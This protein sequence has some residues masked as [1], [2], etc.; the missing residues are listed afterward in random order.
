QL[1]THLALRVECFCVDALLREAVHQEIGAATGDEQLRRRG[2]LPLVVGARVGDLAFALERLVG[3]VAHVYR[4]IQAFLGGLLRRAAPRPNVTRQVEEPAAAAGNF[5]RTPRRFDRELRRG[6]RAGARDLVG[7]GSD[8][9]RAVGGLWLGSAAGALEDLSLRVVAS[10]ETFQLVGRLVVG[11]DVGLGELL[12]RSLLLTDR[13][14]TGLAIQAIQV[15]AHFGTELGERSVRR[16][17]V[18][19][20]GRAALGNR[21]RRA[22]AR[23]IRERC[24]TLHHQQTRNDDSDESPHPRK[25][26]R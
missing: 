22:R 26:S 12:A 19:F 8:I 10:R 20:A 21:E 17:E 23:A 24:R 25:T 16:D 6:R 7:S 9:R 5:G 18:L 1:R 15:V 14:L 2:V 11:R 13:L 3:V 4:A